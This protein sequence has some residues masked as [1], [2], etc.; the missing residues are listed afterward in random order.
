MRKV[1]HLNLCDQSAS[2]T[3]YD[4]SK[5]KSQ[6]TGRGPITSKDWYKANSCNY[7]VICCYKLIRLNVAFGVGFIMVPKIEHVQADMM[8]TL[9]RRILCTMDQWYDLSYEQC[10]Q[11][12]LENSHTILCKIPQIRDLP[13]HFYSLAKKLLSE[14][15]KKRQREQ[16]EAVK[17]IESPPANID[18]NVDK[19]IEK[20]VD[21]GATPVDGSFEELSLT[22]KALSINRQVHHEEGKTEESPSIYDQDA[23]QEL[24]TSDISHVSK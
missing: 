18:D 3:R 20:I 23:P 4:P 9:M 16:E 7:P 21:K 8:H 2:E 24:K 22:D 19:I 11:R 5:F 14:H 10:W 1:V 6:V 12:E 15:E 13:Q 17:A